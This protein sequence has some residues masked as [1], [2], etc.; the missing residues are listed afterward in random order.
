MPDTGPT[1][2][3]CQTMTRQIPLALKNRFDSLP[4]ATTPTLML[5]A[6]ARSCVGIN[7]TQNS[8]II[9]LFQSTVSRPMGQSWCL[10]FLQ[11]CIAYVEDI[12]GIVSPLPATELCTAL[13]GTAPNQCKGMPRQ[14]GDILVWELGNTIHGHVG[15]LIGETSVLYQTVEGN[16]TNSQFIENQGD[17]VYLKNRAKGGTATFKELGFVRVFP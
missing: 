3:I 11:S 14:P 17:G 10:D 16:T 13:W 6:V 1:M 2:L 7:I 5:I 9:S 12:Y 4:K 8:E 15:L